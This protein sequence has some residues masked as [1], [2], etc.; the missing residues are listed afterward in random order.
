MKL[1]TVV[2]GGIFVVALY[3]LQGHRLRPFLRPDVYTNDGK[4][5]P[6]KEDV[7]VLD[8]NQKLALFGCALVFICYYVFLM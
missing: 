5:R 8:K 6:G 2:L 7:E 1:F 3:V 4:L